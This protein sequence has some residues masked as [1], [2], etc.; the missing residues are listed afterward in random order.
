ML[1]NVDII[2]YIS[3][4]AMILI[5]VLYVLGMFLKSIPKI[6]DWTIPSSLLLIGI[7]ISTAMFGMTIE[8]GI[9]GIL[10]AGVSV[11]VN[12]LYRQSFQKSQVVAEA[13]KTQPPYIEPEIDLDSEENKIG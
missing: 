6:P 4:E 2:G 8:A 11:F 1:E 9:Q 3:K 12:Q 10:A 7:L 5:P 13:I